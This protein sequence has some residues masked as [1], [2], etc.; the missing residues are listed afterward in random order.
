MNQGTSF[1]VF[2]GDIDFT[3]FISN[4]GFFKD[5][6]LSNASLNGFVSHVQR[7]GVKVDWA[8]HHA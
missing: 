7:V 2:S 8:G 5:V 6:G 1:A 4:V 3:S